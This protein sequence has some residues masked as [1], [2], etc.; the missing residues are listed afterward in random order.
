MIRTIL[1]A[2]SICVASVANAQPAQNCTPTQATPGDS[3]IT[4]QGKTGEALGDKLAKS[5]GV[6]CPPQTGASDMRVPAPDAG[7]SKMPVIPPPGSPGGD[8]SVRP[9]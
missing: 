1:I 4:T 8:P 2:V 3:G 9:K 5:D 6:L 7:A